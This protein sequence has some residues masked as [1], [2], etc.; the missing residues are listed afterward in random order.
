M[1]K[2]IGIVGMPGSGKSVADEIAKDL[3]FSV[4]IM[5]D[6]IREE[7]A[8][9]GLIL[10][11]Q[12]VGKVM[13]EIRKVGGAAIVAKKCISKIKKVEVTDTHILIEGLRSLAEAC[14]FRENFPCF[15]LI[16]IYASPKTRFQRIYGRNRIDD[17][18]DWQTFI[19]RDKREIE[20][21]IGSVIAI[22]DYAIINEG[23]Y[24]CF[25]ANFRKL[26]KAIL[27]E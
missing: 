18:M 26:L 10:T 2:I 11:A 21:G 13:V 14:E 23:S 20:I 24:C 17:S 8:I 15:K 1:R 7:V 16:A 25:K 22:A 5:G 12:N 4:I 27:N 6:I 3:G 9:R 19:D